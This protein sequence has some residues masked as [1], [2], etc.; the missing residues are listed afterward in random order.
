MA[1]SKLTKRD[2]QRIETRQRI[3]E[4]AMYLFTRKGYTQ[5]SVNDICE[6][7]G[8][9][10]GTFYY[11]FKS[12]DQVYFEEYLKIDEFLTAEMKGFEK[13][14]KSPTKRLVTFTMS[15]F[16]YIDKLGVKLIKVIWSG[17]IDPETKKPGMISPKRPIP[18]MIEQM[19][20]EGQERGELRS[21]VSAATMAQLYVR[22]YRGIIYEWCLQNGKFDL[23]AAC[24]EFTKL[25]I[26]GFKKQ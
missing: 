4:T 1:G 16:E 24:R 3:Y 9:S 19:I 18:P 20:R 7:A 6:K 17:E 15:G 26:E 22:C 5:V 25:V 2:Q 11:Y 8:V 13:K 12:K 21:D 23:V 10:K 14:Y